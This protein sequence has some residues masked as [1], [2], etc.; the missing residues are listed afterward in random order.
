MNK[1]A[2]EGTV[3]LTR[4]TNTN[5]GKRLSGMELEGMRKQAHRVYEVNS[6]IFEDE[7]DALNALGV[8]PIVQGRSRGPPVRLF[9]PSSGRLIEQKASSRA[10]GL[11]AVATVSSRPA[12]VCVDRRR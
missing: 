7:L 5:T 10:R 4:W 9:A 6:H 12:A 11:G 8:I 3:T 1:A 2:R